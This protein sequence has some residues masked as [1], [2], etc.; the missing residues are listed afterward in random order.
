[1]KISVNK[2][3]CI[4][5]LTCELACSFH[6]TK[7]FSLQN[8]SIRMD[9]DSEGGIRVAILPTCDLCLN[10]KVPLCMEFC[11]AGAVRVIR[12]EI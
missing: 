3:K 7:E 11:P 2:E 9:F 5:C 4:G 8:A 1:M 10:E 12:A 6:H